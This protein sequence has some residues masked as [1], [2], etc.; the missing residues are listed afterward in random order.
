MTKKGGGRVPPEI[1]KEI[2]DAIRDHLPKL[3]EGIV[4]DWS[5]VRE[6]WPSL[7]GPPTANGPGNAST[8]RR[9]FRWVK[10]VREEALSPQERIE[11]KAIAALP[12]VPSV[13]EGIVAVR[14]GGGMQIMRMLEE[15]AE[16]A[17]MLRDKA[18]TLDAEGRRQIKNPIFLDTSLKRRMDLINTYLR[19][20]QEI[21]DLRQVQVFFDEILSIIRD[22]IAPAD[23]AITKRVIARLEQLQARRDAVR[24]AS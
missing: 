10:K 5:A 15:M 21:H 20:Y 1:E 14:A 3:E 9:F 7:I 4:A 13:G 24:A 12:A 18:M 2:L 8:D 23:E 17:D 16:E 6:R 22:E 19:V 11:A